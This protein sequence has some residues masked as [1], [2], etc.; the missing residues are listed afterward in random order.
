MPPI[1]R[2]YK[3][4]EL[5]Y[6]APDTQPLTAF[7]TNLQPG[8]RIELFRSANIRTSATISA[9]TLIGVNP[10]GARGTILAG[11]TTGVSNSTWYNIN[12]DIGHDGWCVSDN[13]TQITSTVVQTTP[14]YFKVNDRVR[15][16]R[17]ANSRSSAAIANNLL[18]VVPKDALGTITAGP[19]KVGTINWYRINF[20]T[21]TQPDGFVASDNYVVVADIVVGPDPGPVIIGDNNI[22]LLPASMIDDAIAK[23]LTDYAAFGGAGSNCG[24]F[25]SSAVIVATSSFAGYT[26]ADSRLLQQLRFNIQGAHCP[27]G[28]GGYEMQ[29]ELQFAVTAC[30]ARM[31]ARIWNQLTATEKSKIDLLMKGLLV[32]AA[33][34]GSSKNPKS[35]FNGSMTDKPAWATGNPNFSLAKPATVQAARVFMGS[36]S[37]VTSFLNGFNK[38]AFYQQVQAA[39]LTNMAKVMATHSYP[40]NALVESVIQDLDWRFTPIKGI[41]IS[42]VKGLM[43]AAISGNF[44]KPVEAGYNNGAGVGGRAK[45]MKNAAGLPNKG[46]LGMA[47]ELDSVDAEGIRSSMSY[48][49]WGIRVTLNLMTLLMCSGELDISAAHQNRAQIGMVDYKYKSDNGYYSY[50]HAGGSGSENWTSALNNTWGWSYTMGQW[51]NMLKPHLD[52]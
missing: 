33:F 8:D 40:S 37:A 41:S 34:S 47:H 23:P 28:D 4:S 20:D 39:G 9:A 45:I 14:S 25:G 6:S 13:Y 18:G 1:S 38:A 35:G 36:A 43:E 27:S 10:H 32:G 19:T 17:A 22:P 48:A 3:G 52:A 46:A 7:L 24:Y 42:N 21:A 2:I 49:T 50:A 26:K 11:P 15:L 29:H 12:F 51:F 5:V 16:F 44:S 31:N 30:I